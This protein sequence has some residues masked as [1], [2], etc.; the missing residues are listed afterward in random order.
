MVGKRQRRLSQQ[1]SH[2]HN[3]ARASLRILSRSPSP[4]TTHQ[5]S[6]ASRCWGGQQALTL[7]LI[8]F[9]IMSAI[10]QVYFLFSIP[11]P[12]QQST[13]FQF[14][15]LFLRSISLFTSTLQ[16]S[17]IYPSSVYPSIFITPANFK[18]TNYLQPINHHHHHAFQR[19]HRRF[20]PRLHHLGPSSRRS[21][22]YSS[23]TCALPHCPTLHRRHRC[24]PLQ[25]PPQQ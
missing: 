15:S 24:R 19:F 22:S 14:P 2:H 7:I 25:P 3:R 23:S 9:Y 11:H 18:A 16:S 4:T 17:D 12:T 13:I 1:P 21:S 20:H 6:S 5:L 10:L 8:C